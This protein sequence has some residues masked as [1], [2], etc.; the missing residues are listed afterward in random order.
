MHS[1]DAF[2]REFRWAFRWEF[3]GNFG[4]DAIDGNGKQ[5]NV[6]YVRG[7]NVL[8]DVGEWFIGV[9]IHQIR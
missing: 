8:R 4:D 6:V 1:V 3:G 5:K 2:G 7:V 9:I